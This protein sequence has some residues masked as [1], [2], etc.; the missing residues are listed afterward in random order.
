[1]V[2]QT[3][4]RESHLAEL[5]QCSAP[6]EA[7]T[8]HVGDVHTYHLHNFARQGQRP[9]PSTHLPFPT[10]LLLGP[11]LSSGSLQ[12]FSLLLLDSGFD[13]KPVGVVSTVRSSQGVCV[14]L[15]SGAH[16]VHRSL[17][18]SWCRVTPTMKC[19]LMEREFYRVI[20]GPAFLSQG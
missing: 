7:D 20:S 13:R 16:G 17:S 3:I 1:M 8:V 12:A 9:R 6:V 2:S 15:Q 10:L 5:I 14:C 18:E 19:P 11:P 4:R